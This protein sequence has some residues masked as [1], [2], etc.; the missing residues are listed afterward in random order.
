MCTAKALQHTLIL[1]KNAAEFEVPKYCY[2]LTV[3]VL[4]VIICFTAVT[5]KYSVYCVLNY[6]YNKKLLFPFN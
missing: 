1:S 3:Q 4:L 6:F 2:S 5:L